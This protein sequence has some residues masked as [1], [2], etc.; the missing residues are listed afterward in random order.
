MYTLRALNTSDTRASASGAKRALAES[1]PRGP[2]I[3]GTDDIKNGRDSLGPLSTSESSLLYVYLIGNECITLSR[4]R[5][6]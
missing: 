1:V 5:A 2:N 6:W 4:L 3:W